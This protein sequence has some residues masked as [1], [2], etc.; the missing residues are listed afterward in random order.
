[1]DWITQARWAPAL[2]SLLGCCPSAQA[3]P[4]LVADT[5]SGARAEI[6]LEHLR[7]P[8]APPLAAQRLDFTGW[9]RPGRLGAGLSLGVW[10]I[11]SA[12]LPTGTMSAPSLWT[13]QLGVHWRMPLANRLRLNISGWIPLQANDAARSSWP[14]QNPD[15]AYAARLEVQW[16]S[17]RWGGLI[18]EYGAIGVQLQGS[19][20]GRLLLRARHGGP[21]IYYRAKF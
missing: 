19:S 16:S 18:P 17:P 4:L 2:F 15:A 21:M 10:S 1:M 9:S 7:N 8:A 20:S 14:L 13:P 11:D 12:P 5:A 3:L 6:V